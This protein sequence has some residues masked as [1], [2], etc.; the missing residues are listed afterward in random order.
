MSW[1]YP[2]LTLVQG[3]ASVVVWGDILFYSG[4]EVVHLCRQWEM[5]KH[6]ELPFSFV[7]QYMYN[8]YIVYVIFI[9]FFFFE[10]KERGDTF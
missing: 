4:P 6:M 3:I 8:I 9:F 10:E 5:Q 1:D 7:V 2:D